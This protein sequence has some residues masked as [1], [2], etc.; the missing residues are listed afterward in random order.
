MNVLFV[1]RGNVG[2]SQMAAALLSRH[3][4]FRVSSAGLKVNGDEGQRLSD[5]PLAEPVI[6]FMQREGVAIGDSTR[7]QLTPEMLKSNDLVLIL[8]PE[9]ELPNWVSDAGNIER[10]DIQDP[11][12]MDDAG[13]E[14]VVADIKRRI[15]GLRDSITL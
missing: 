15:C 12:G 1:C 6:R 9:E 14:Q 2:R 5:I 8:A 7:T 10:W 4:G 11:K 3:E 13:Y